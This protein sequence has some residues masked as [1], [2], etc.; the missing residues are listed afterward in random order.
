[1]IITIQRTPLEKI[2]NMWGCL[3]AYRR[4]MGWRYLG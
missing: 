2:Y 4:R 1:M 3:A